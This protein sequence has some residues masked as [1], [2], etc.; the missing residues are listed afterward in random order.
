MHVEPGQHV[1]VPL[2]TMM[3]NNYSKFMGKIIKSPP[4]AP[5]VDIQVSEG[6]FG[7]H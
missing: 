4:H 3:N 6:G 7:K 1:S 2:K 5:Y